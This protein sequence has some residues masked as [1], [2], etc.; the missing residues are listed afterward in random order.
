MALQ[1]ALLRSAAQ[2]RTSLYLP[3]LGFVWLMVNQHV[4]EHA[5]FGVADAGEGLNPGSRSS[6]ATERA[7]SCVA[8]SRSPDPI[9][10][11]YRTLLRE[12]RRRGIFPQLGSN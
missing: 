12:L 8:G 10:K 2:Q 7:A 3:S 9:S 1:H 11:R 6:L 5:A 4:T